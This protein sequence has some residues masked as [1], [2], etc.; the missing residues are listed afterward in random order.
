MTGLVDTV[1]MLSLRLI[2]IDEECGKRVTGDDI[3]NINENQ[4]TPL[5]HK[6]LKRMTEAVVKRILRGYNYK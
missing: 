1:R 2:G 4:V 6:D 5:T 3:K